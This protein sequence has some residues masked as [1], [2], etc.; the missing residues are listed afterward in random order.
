MTAPG[1]DEAEVAA[2]RTSGTPGTV[3]VIG[4]G[5]IGVPLAAR[6]TAAGW[7]V[8]GVDVLPEVVESFGA[9][10]SHIAEEPGVAE[11]LAA[12]HAQGRV[13]ATASHADAAS[14][15]DVVVMIVPL[16]LTDAHTPN[17]AW[18]DAASEAVGQGLRPGTLVTYETTLPVGDTRQRYGPLL[19]RASGLAL[20]G[21]D[22]FYL[23]FSPERVFSGRI[24]RDLSTYPKLVGGVDQASTERAMA[25]YQSVLDAEIWDLGTSETAEFAKLAETTYRDVNIALANEFARYADDV[26]V[27]ITQVIRGANSQPYSH[28]HQPGIGVGGHCIPVYPYFLLAREPGLSITSESRRINDGQVAR[29]VTAVQESLGD[30]DGVTVLVLGLTY[31]EGVH[32]MAYSRGPA[33]V[34]E[35]A[36][37][38]ARVHG[39]DP[40]LSDAEIREV[41]AEP[42]RWGDPSEARVIVTQ[43]ADP[44]WLELDPA[45]FPNL[46]VIYDG[47]NSLRDV[48]IP[49]HVG[50]VAVGH[51]RGR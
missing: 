40:L 19:Q 36:A 37:R 47:R 29:A 13:S 33:V 23:A 11:L 25:F 27:D 34:A 39:Y 4:L 38:G 5:K 15:A 49:P 31:R 7:N 28:I 30:L 43:T 3:A 32:E 35:L 21:E 12:G 24:L 42:Y 22:R 10:R 17:Y 50:Y 18:M 6:Y 45:W 41:G 14:R 51:T 26:G 48:A 46:D 8:I 9:G 16:M 20:D 2:V 1:A 44:A